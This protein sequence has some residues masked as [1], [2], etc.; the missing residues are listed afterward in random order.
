VRICVDQESHAAGE[1]VLINMT[2][3]S[4]DVWSGNVYSR[5]SG[6]TYYGA[7]TMKGANSLRVEACVLGRFFCS[8]NLWSRIV[9][10]PQELITSSQAAPEPRS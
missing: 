1:S 8:G 10:T 2:P 6:A 5:A 4:A 3:K 7:I 9:P